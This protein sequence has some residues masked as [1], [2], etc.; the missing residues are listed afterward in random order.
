M[1][2]MSRSSAP[3][4]T[5]SAPSIQWNMKSTQR[6]TGVHGASKKAKGPLPDR[7]RWIASR[8]R[9]P[10]AGRA[11][12]AGAMARARIAL[13]TRA[14]SRVCSLAPARASTRPRA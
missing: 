4:N 11:R 10:V 12:S 7:K 3:E 8:S 6:N 13:S 9:T 2:A 1:I 14:S 5:A